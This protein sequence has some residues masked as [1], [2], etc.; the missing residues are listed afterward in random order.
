M[1]PESEN[2]PSN[3]TDSPPQQFPSFPRGKGT[4]SQLRPFSQG[5]QDIDFDESVQGNQ[6]LLDGLINDKN[7]DPTHLNQQP[8]SWFSSNSISV[9]T[10]TKPDGSTETKRIERNSNGDEEVTVTQSFGDQ[11]YTY[12]KRTKSDGS[13]E[14]NENFVNMDHDKVDEI[15][16][17]VLGSH[18]NQQKL[19]DSVIKGSTPDEIFKSIL[20]PKLIGNLF[21]E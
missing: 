19:K 15:R 18:P 13:A 3:A 17:K 21:D 4:F 2:N 6:Q 14:I 11:S 9:S 1:K 7:S 20:F 8:K 5:K 16:S 10:I 12:K